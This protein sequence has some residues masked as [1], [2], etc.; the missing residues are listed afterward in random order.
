MNKIKTI[1][2]IIFFVAAT[3]F[4]SYAPPSGSW[5]PGD[6]DPTVPLH[7]GI[8]FLLGMLIAYFGRKLFAQKKDDPS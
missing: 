7:G 5:N 6:T 1:I 3:S 2:T 8:F 4:L